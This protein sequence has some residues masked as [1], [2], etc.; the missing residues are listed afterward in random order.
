LSFEE[1][2]H[3]EKWQRAMN[4][5]IRAIKHNNTWG[6]TDLPKGARSIGVK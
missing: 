1:V 3:E 4:E 6:L 5:K 2:M